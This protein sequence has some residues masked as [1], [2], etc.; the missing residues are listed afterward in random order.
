MSKLR[1]QIDLAHVDDALESPPEPDLRTY[2]VLTR[3][4][5]EKPHVWAGWLDAVDDRMAL[6]F[7]REHYGQDQECVGIWVIPRDRIVPADAIDIE[8]GSGRSR[9]FTVLVQPARGDGH[10]YAGEVEA[11]S[12]AAA[13]AR[14]RAEI[15]GVPDAFSFWVVESDAIAATRPEDVIWRYTDQS[16]RLARGYSGEV[17]RKW[18]EIREERALADYE[19]DD[20]EEAF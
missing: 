12:P 6:E 20:L 3:L 19:K 2:A 14:A 4:R 16:Y 15:D 8:S 18:R 9:R 11:D 7:A 13:L 10:S 17:A 1:D 5:P